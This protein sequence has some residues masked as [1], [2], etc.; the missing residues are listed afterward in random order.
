MVHQ[1]PPPSETA[2]IQ[3]H[4]SHTLICSSFPTRGTNFHTLFNFV[5][6]SW[7]SRQLL[8]TIS[9][10]R[11]SKTMI[12]STPVKPLPTNFF[13][14]I[15]LVHPLRSPHTP[16]CYPHPLFDHLHLFSSSALLYR[17]SIFLLLFLLLCCIL[18]RSVFLLFHK[19]RLCMQ[20]K[21]F[22]FIN[23]C[24]RQPTR[25]SFAA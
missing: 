22:F 9:N 8:T 12:F 25:L 7:S 18:I 5:L 14:C 15:H 16:H 1:Q 4:R 11:P 10:H 2:K 17:F 20:K 6:P 23:L 19:P 13:F 21:V 3:N 24:F